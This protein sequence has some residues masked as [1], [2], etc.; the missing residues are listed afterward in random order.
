MSNKN[1]PDINADD[2]EYIEHTIDTNPAY[3]WLRVK[4]RCQ[5]VVGDIVIKMMHDYD[6]DKD[7]D[8]IRPE[9]VSHVNKAARKYKVVHVDQ[10]G[11]PWLK[12][13]KANGGM[14]TE[15]I[16]APNISPSYFAP[17]PD[18]ADHVI[19]SEEGAEFDPIEAAKKRRAER[20]EIAKQ[21]KKNRKIFTTVDEV[22]AFLRDLKRGETFWAAPR[23]CD[24]QASQIEHR[25]R[26]HQ[27]IKGKKKLD[28]VID[29]H[30][31]RELY[32]NTEY[33]AV[34][35]DFSDTYNTDW[36]DKPV[37]DIRV[38]YPHQLID[39]YIYTTKP[40]S[41]ETK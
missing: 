21:N 8:F 7:K 13:L 17:D 28:E 40:L 34:N 2:I 30:R 29:Y 6:Y 39:H 4:D 24:E 12:V 1:N 10:Y 3:D 14:G 25:V 35:V 41:Y 33:C 22:S 15:M 19:L 32:I 26:S 37:K 23:G 20:R 31:D 5:F 38:I 11:V 9:T 36:N 27:L 16:C 18:Y